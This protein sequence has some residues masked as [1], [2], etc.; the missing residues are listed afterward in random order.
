MIDVDIQECISKLS[1][2]FLKKS[3]KSGYGCQV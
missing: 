3:K 1:I 2:S